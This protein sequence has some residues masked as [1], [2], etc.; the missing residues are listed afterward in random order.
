MSLQ[1]KVEMG[2][3]LGTDEFRINEKNVQCTRD[4]K[5]ARSGG[6]GYKGV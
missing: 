4:R 6:F 5:D 3:G 1:D 2:V